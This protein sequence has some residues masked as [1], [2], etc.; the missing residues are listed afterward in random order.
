MLVL[1]HQRVRP[2]VPQS[3]APHGEPAYVTV[4]HVR[5]LHQLRLVLAVQLTTS[6]QDGSPPLPGV[7]EGQGRAA[8][9]G[10]KSNVSAVDADYITNL[11]K[12]FGRIFP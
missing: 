11:Q 5:V 4:C 6:R 2:A 9:L 1:H 3:D 10:L 8:E 7:F 12:I